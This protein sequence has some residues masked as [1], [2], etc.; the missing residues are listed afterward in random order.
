MDD[1]MLRKKHAIYRM[2]STLP[3]Y[4]GTNDLRQITKNPHNYRFSSYSLACEQFFDGNLIR[5]ITLKGKV[6]NNNKMERMN[7]EIRE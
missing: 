2:Q 1:P 7:G 3:S 5:K 6:H 4:L